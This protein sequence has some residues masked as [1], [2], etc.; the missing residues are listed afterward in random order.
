LPLPF[1]MSTLYQTFVLH[2][3]TNVCDDLR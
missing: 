2:S 3:T 1:N